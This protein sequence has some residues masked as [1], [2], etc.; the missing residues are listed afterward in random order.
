MLKKFEVHQ[1]IRKM[2]RVRVLGKNTP[3]KTLTIPI[4]QIS[5]AENATCD[6]I[7]LKGYHSPLVS[8][9]KGYLKHPERDFYI[10]VPLADLA[11][12]AITY[13]ELSEVSFYMAQGRTPYELCLAVY[14][15]D[16]ISAEE[17]DKSLNLL[18]MH[19]DPDTIFLVSSE[20]EGK[21]WEVY[22]NYG[23]SL[24]TAICKELA[25]SPKKLAE[26][27]RLKTQGLSE[28]TRMLLSK[29]YALMQYATENDAKAS[30]TDAPKAVLDAWQIV[31]QE[32]LEYDPLSGVIC[33]SGAQELN[34]SG[35]TVYLLPSELAVG[36]QAPW[37]TP[38]NKL[39]TLNWIAP[40]QWTLGFAYST[41]DEVFKHS[42]LRIKSA[43]VFETPT[44]GSLMF[45]LEL[46]DVNNVGVLTCK[47]KV[48]G[49][50]IKK[51]GKM[52]S[53][54]GADYF[55]VRKAL[56]EALTLNIPYLLSTVSCKT[57]SGSPQLHVRCDLPRGKKLPA[58]IASRS[59]NS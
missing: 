6:N 27:F 32:V 12:W 42:L 18:T 28:D 48:E 38:F 9:S 22:T 35:S 55:A 7:P 5:W 46:D 17:G 44:P 41:S 2:I 30:P 24:S 49:V 3:Y 56:L 11:I 13:K 1:I 58:V 19:G 15:E 23:T 45:K 4:A 8:M 21:L 39:E 25:V 33:S 52:L 10:E 43:Y 54:E 51:R 16:L 47:P 57:S 29:A 31:K 37:V 34:F 26:H 40:G 36:L 59:I 20:S 53:F 14:T 50:V